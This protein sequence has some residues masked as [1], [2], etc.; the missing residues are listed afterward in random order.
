MSQPGPNAAG[1]RSVETKVI[2]DHVPRY[3]YGIA[4]S[5]IFQSGDDV[6]Y[7]FYDEI[8]EQFMCRKIRWLVSR[9]SI[10]LVAYILNWPTNLLVGNESAVPKH[11]LGVN[12]CD[13]GSTQEEYCARG[14]ESLR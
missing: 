8:T 11:S 6:R 10:T 9:V 12:A 2:N 3:H 1:S 14:D 4:I 13:V 5:E 7:R